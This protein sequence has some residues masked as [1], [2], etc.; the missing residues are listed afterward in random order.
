MKR[1]TY[2]GFFI[3]AVAILWVGCSKEDDDQEAQITDQQALTDMMTGDQDIEGLD[4]WSNDDDGSG[5]GTF[6]DPMTPL[7]WARHGTRHLVSVQVEI[8][9]DTLATITR[10]HSFDGFIRVVTDTSDTAHIY[11]DKPM[12]NT[13]VRKAHAVRVDRT[14]FPRRN[15]RISEVTPE[16]LASS[17]PNPHTIWPIEV[18]IYVTTLFEPILI[19]QVTDPLNTCFARD[20]LPAIAAQSQV[21]VRV[22]ANRDSSA[23]AFMHP[24]VYQRVAHSR[25]ELRDDGVY[26]DETAGDGIFAASF[27]VGDRLAIHAVGLDL[28]DRGTLYDSALPYDAGGWALPYRVIS[29]R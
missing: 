5:G 1:L 13:L 16:V 11:I 9:G 22:T 7:R 25:L 26:P 18:R 10:T 15:W 8:Q 21:I 6:D 23:L 29:P 28:L 4:A 2:L 12:S 27:N 20:N 24:R 19:A 3:V 17:A 14:R